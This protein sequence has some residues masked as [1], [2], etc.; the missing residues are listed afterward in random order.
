MKWSW[1]RL[2][3]IGV[4]L[5]ILAIPLHASAQWN[6]PGSGA[7]FAKAQ[8]MPAGNVPTTGVTGRNVTVSWSVNSFPD[9]TTVNGYLVRRYDA[10]TGTLLTVGTGCSG[11]ITAL[12]CTENAVPP[13]TWRYTVQPR[14]GNWQGLEGATSS[15][16]TVGSPTLSFGSP[17]PITTLPTTLAGT[18]G[19]FVTGSTVTYRLD[20]P[21]SGT[22]LSG[23]TTPT[24]MPNNGN[25]TV[26]VTI[27]KG[28]TNGAHVVYAIGNQGDVASAPITVNVTPPTP[29]DLRLRNILIAGTPRQTDRIEVTFSQ[30]LDVASI[31]STW[32]GDSTN[33]LI[34]GN[35][36]ALVVITNNA[37]PSG[38][39]MLTVA[40]TASACGGQFHFGNVDLGSPNFVTGNTYYGGSGASQTTV[41][42]NATTFRLDITL[43]AIAFGPAPGTVGTSVRATYTPDPVI[44][45]PSGTPV[46]G[47][48]SR[49]AVQF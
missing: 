42:W 32:T 34:T 15:S 24:P 21:V 14:H 8:Q 10:S 12:N 38:N 11:L 28:T 43:G 36:V 2:A 9:G 46:T 19:N 35:N 4:L 20:D 23:T 13:G 41:A 7:A 37:A 49:T 33:Q 16:T 5:A 3:S 40:T 47:T 31:C 45:N 1:D 44:T 18:V 30:R 17:P 22:L 48:A 25:A 39:D 26:D 29:T 27:P 6:A